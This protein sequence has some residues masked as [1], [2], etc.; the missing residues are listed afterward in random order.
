MSE[1]WTAGDLYEP[2]A[3]RWSRLVA[4]EFVPWLRVRRDCAWLDVGCGTGA[5]CQAILDLAWPGSVSGVDPS[6]AFVARARERVKGADF[7]IGTAV[8]LPFPTGSFE[9][10]VSGLVLNFVPDHSRMAEEMRRAAKPGGTVALYVWDYAGEMQLM[11]RFWDAAGE[12]DPAALQ[13]DEGARFPICNP[14]RLAALFRAAGLQDVQSRP[15]EVPT[16]FRDFDDY[17]TPFLSGQAPAPAYCVSLPE[18]GR[19]RLRERLRETLPFETDG[20]LR[21]K[22]RAWAV[23]GR[24]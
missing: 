21:L 24:T 22:A 1:Q 5:L 4:R 12:L 20:S 11:R 9:S 23:R 19:A 15:I 10:V 6:E 8:D 17:W 3:G 2:Y 13:L 16:V 7:E 14:E 18:A